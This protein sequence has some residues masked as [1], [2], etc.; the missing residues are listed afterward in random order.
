[1]SKRTE[2]NDAL[3]AAMK[4]GDQNAVGTLRLINAALKQKDI[5]ARPSG[6]EVTEADILSMLQG[7]IKQ[8]KE[9][10]QIFRENKREDLATKEEAE[11]AVIER[12]LPAQMDDAEVAAIIDKLIKETGAAS[13]KD[14]GKVMG[15][16]KTQY[17]GQLD[18]GKAGAV[19]KQK[20]G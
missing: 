6:K 2:F 10:I 19:V 18:M 12:F 5:D 16:L 7:M 17:A 3:K 13:Q 4:A 9:S 11:V 8:R 20:L 1:M 14:M 15:A